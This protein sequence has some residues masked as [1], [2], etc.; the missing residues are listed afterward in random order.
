MLH[1]PVTKSLQSCVTSAARSHS[2]SQHA[3]I[4]NGEKL[5]TRKLNFYVSFFIKYFNKP[6]D[7]KTKPNLCCVCVNGMES[8]IKIRVKNRSR[9]GQGT[10]QCLFYNPII[11][12]QCSSSP[13]H[14][15]QSDC[16]K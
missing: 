3:G 16:N 15:F 1:F 12:Q 2:T 4:L 10:G 11:L 7:L 6:L 8:N 13:P 14:S 9:S 5:L